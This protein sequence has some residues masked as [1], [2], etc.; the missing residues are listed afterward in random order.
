[1]HWLWLKNLGSLFVRSF[2]TV[3]DILF[4]H[5]NNNLLKYLILFYV[6]LILKNVFTLNHRVVK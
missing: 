2:K 5:I 4:S 1:M 3:H 6:A